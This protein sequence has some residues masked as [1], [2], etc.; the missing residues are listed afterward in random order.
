VVDACVRR[1]V[2]IVAACL[3]V[4]GPE[5]KLG[6]YANLGE[7]KPGAYGRAAKTG[8]RGDERA[9]P[10]RAA[11]AH[12]LPAQSQEISRTPV[13]IPD[14]WVPGY[15]S[16]ISGEVIPYPSAYPGQTRALLTRATDGQKRIEWE[17]TQPPAAPPG[18]TVNFVWHAG[19]AS[20]Y[21]AHRFTL[22]INGTPCATFASGR[23]TND[24]E[25][26]VKGECDATLSFKTTRVGTFNE[27]FGLMVFSVPARLVSSGRP[28]FSVVGEA[29]GSLDYYMT[30]LQPVRD[31]TRVLAEQAILRGGQRVL[32]LETSRIANAEPARVVSGQTV[33][34]SGTIGPAYT[35]VFIPAPTVAPAQVPVSVEAGG[36]QVFEATLSMTPVRRWEIHLLPHSHVD[37]GYS[38][39]QPE[40][41]RKQWKNLRDAV[42]L[43]QKTAA[44]PEAA[45]FK[46]NVE[47]LWP[48]ESY[49]RQA[50][51]RERAAF[52][53]AIRHG[54]IGL[55]ANY[56]N[57]L[58]GLAS[59]EE[60]SHWTDAAR[61]M[62]ARYGLP[63]I[64]SAMHTDIPGLSWTSVRA[65][66]EGGVRY[67]SSG[68]NFM[69]SMPDRGDRIGHT[70][71]ALGDRPFW[72][73]SP[74]GNE[75]LLF[76]MAG[77]GYSWFHGLNI[78]SIA[79]AGRLPLLDYVRDLDAAGYA[80]DL[81]QVRYTIGGDNGPVD[82]ELPDFVKAWNETFEWPQ[83]VINTADA[84]FAEFER[85]HGAQLPTL[86]GDMTPY[87]EDGAVSSAGEEALVRASARRLVQA[88]TLW[89]LRAPARSPSREDE[90][91]EAWRN[92]LLW[93]EH[94][95]GAADSVSQ[96]DRAD[97]VGQWLYKRQFAVEADRRSRTLLEAATAAA[98]AQPAPAGPKARP[99]G[100]TTIEIANTLSW[101]RG[102][103]VLL[104]ADVS[105]ARDRVTG[106]NGRPVPSQRL[107]DGRLAV[108]VD[109]VPALGAIRLLLAGG[110]A[111]TSRRT[112]KVE[113]DLTIANDLVRLG[114][115]AGTGDIRTLQFSRSGGASPEFVSPSHGLN[116]YLY[117]PG[118]DPAKAQPA[119]PARASV[120]DAGP[121][122]A[123]VR[124]ESDA[125]G[126]RSLVRRVTLIA[127]QVVVNIEDALDK[128]AVRAKESAHV[129]FP[130]NLPGAT[131]RVDEGA[132]V[133]VVERDQI[134]GSCRDFIGAHSVVDVST[135]TAGISLATLDAPLVEIG[136]LTDERIDP[137]VRQR[138]W[139]TRTA[140]GPAVYAYLLNNYWHTNYKA[141]QEGPLVF[142]FALKPHGGSANAGARAGASAVS[143]SGSSTDEVAIR[144]FGAEQ[145]QP[146]LAYVVLPQAPMPR[147][148]FRVQGPGVV[149]SSIRSGGQQGGVIARLYNASARP[150]TA[151]IIAS[152]PTVPIR[153]DRIEEDRT[154]GRLAD[155]TIRMRPFATAIVRVVTNDRSRAEA[156]KSHN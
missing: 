145:E 32:R 136:A 155:A 79:K 44:Y 30:F 124:I 25:W 70:L 38:D 132:A 97:V 11:A 112:V 31:W 142:R 23:D 99:P 52:I 80:W 89:C 101:P 45:R 115:D 154:A 83:L 93:H 55:Q 77:R 114:V 82:P 129:A 133:V 122:V 148:T 49:L 19:L 100:P 47:G 120:E 78:G 63:P 146:L 12:A 41:E 90:Q 9:V 152:R 96:P 140:E 88:E 75:R 144:Q 135:G 123:T 43:A 16:Y 131:V 67:F 117:V 95:W 121:L 134:D 108:L 8:H 125:P 127:G 66:A 143:G 98:V 2:W 58:T 103:V 59:P 14:R 35:S 65:L 50:P 76:W 17:T 116:S 22:S 61:Q 33:L 56:T 111:S 126:A 156:R 153:V 104:P 69:P 105:A 106:A 26:S 92:V 24:R 113:G 21:G 118:R 4:A 141:D 151:R 119:G 109:R 51:E 53:D 85:R 71:N 130:F 3:V 28:R 18:E 86:A 13:S 5:L 57:I 42:A 110:A 60:L 87:W 36:R 91:A 1:V 27:L 150:A 20:G 29:A 7:L 40:V 149:V 46:W 64:R 10:A 39:P 137:K 6:A 37:I 81:V 68:P 107:K 62:R 147:A 102:G 139:R 54:A 73:A 72:W 128:T 94:T 15:D 48:V 74:S 34:W 138:T 84:M